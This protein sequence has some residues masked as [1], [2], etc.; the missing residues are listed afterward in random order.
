MATDSEGFIEPARRHKQPDLNIVFLGGSTTECMYVAPDNR[1]PHLTAVKL[2]QALGLKINGINA[3]FSGNNSMHSLLLLLGKVVPLRPDYVVLMHGVDDIGALSSNGTYWIK[4]GSL[5]LFEEERLSVEDAGKV[6][7]KT[8]IPYS[9]EQL[10]RGYESLLDLVASGVPRRR[11]RR[12]PA[13]RTGEPRWG[14][15]S[16]ARS[17]RSCGWHRRGASR[18]CS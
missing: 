15:T 2:E 13:R 11:R 4:S 6:L 10:T 1:F 16:R 9:S 8:L 12:R 5:R 7:V 17:G 18:R 14:A 3:G